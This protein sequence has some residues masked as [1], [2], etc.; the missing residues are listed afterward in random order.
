MLRYVKICLCQQSLTSILTFKNRFDFDGILS[1]LNNLEQSQGQ[2]HTRRSWPGCCICTMLHQIETVMF[3]LPLWIQTPP[4]KVQ[5]GWIHR[6]LGSITI[7]QRSSRNLCMNFCLTCLARILLA[8]WTQHCYAKCKMNKMDN[9]NKMNNMNNNSLCFFMSTFLPS[10]PS[11]SASVG[12]WRA[13][14]VVNFKE[15]L[16]WHLQARL[17]T[18]RA[19]DAGSD[20]AKWLKRTGTYFF[21]GCWCINPAN[22]S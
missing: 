19:G 20:Q 8:G 4:E 15:G 14:L 13:D 10:E 9:M 21:G 5:Y 2:N 22:C 1:Y 16:A 6:V 12:T 11:H 3:L 18:W 7:I 17:R